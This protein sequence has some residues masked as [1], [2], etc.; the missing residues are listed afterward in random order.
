MDAGE[1]VCLIDVR[2]P[3]EFQQARIDGA[4]LIPMREIP[5][6]ISEIEGEADN[7][8]VVF[9][10]HHGMRSADVANW[11]RGQGIGECQ[12]MQGGIDQWSREIDPSVPRY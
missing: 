1:A 4:R 9:F 7:A 10:C 12:T 6:R 11:V 2:E 8:T 3:H 5:S